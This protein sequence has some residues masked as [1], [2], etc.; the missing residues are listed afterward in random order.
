MTELRFQAAVERI[1][2]VVFRTPD[3]RWE[4]HDYRVEAIAERVGLDAYD[5]V[6]DFRD[7]EAAMDAL[8]RPL[9]G[10]LLAE[11]GPSSPL[12]LARQ[13]LRELAPSVPPPARL[14]EIALTDGRGKRV[15]VG[16]PFRAI[17]ERVA[18]TEPEQP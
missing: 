18:K 16:S 13:L 10:Q 5:V 12:D 4:G 17:V 2:S 8:L 1:L 6:V 14:A 11:P 7:L 9:Q 15:A 3:G